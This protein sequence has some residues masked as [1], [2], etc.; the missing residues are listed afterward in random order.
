MQELGES[1]MVRH[2]DIG[3]LASELGI[4][5][6]VCI[7]APEYSSKLSAKDTTAIHLF[8][9]KNESLQLAQEISSGD[10]VLV[11]ASRSEK[12]E[13]LAEELEKQIALL[14][15]KDLDVNN[16]QSDEGER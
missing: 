4:D 12:F 9:D 1:S 5:H 6:L 14:I 2:A 13:E 8:T 11:K 16:V 15:D 3:T 10:V 7:G